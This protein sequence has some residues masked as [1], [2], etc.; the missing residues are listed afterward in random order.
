MAALFIDLNNFV[1]ACILLYDLLYYKLYILEEF[2][3]HFFRIPDYLDG[4]LN[5]YTD[6][7]IV[8]RLLPNGNMSHLHYIIKSLSVSVPEFRRFVINNIY[9][10]LEPLDG[11]FLDFCYGLTL[12]FLKVINKVL[13]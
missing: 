5:S 8:L 6:L 3:L 11:A 12:K 10:F 4:I 13:L 9:W 1:N 2:K 7:S